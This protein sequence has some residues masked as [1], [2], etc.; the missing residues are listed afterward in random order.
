M[1]FSRCLEGRDC[2]V[3][4]HVGGRYAILYAHDGKLET[5]VEVHSAWGT[6]EW[7]VQDAFEA[8][9]RVG[10]VANSDGHKGRPSACY[11]GASFFNGGLT[12]FI[13]DRLDRDAIFECM[14]RRHHYATTGNRMYLVVTA[15]LASD[16][17]LF[18]RDP[19]VFERPQS[20]PSRRLMMGDIARTQEEEVAIE[21]TVHG[22]APIERVE[23][24]WRPRHRMPSSPPPPTSEPRPADVPGRRIPWPSPHHQLGTAHFRST[25][26]LLAALKSSTTGTSTAASET[27]RQHP[28]VD[29]RHDGQLR[30]NRHVA[31]AGRRAAFV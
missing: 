12:C 30:R 10:I 26:T 24:S 11:P 3:A 13:T 29:G 25:A 9:Y 8:G 22:S 17:E 21:V 2:I 5:A 18:L 16:A 20:Q 19:A 7:I 27:G 4:A 14:R 15:T 31:R 1:H 6:F 23:I 28:G